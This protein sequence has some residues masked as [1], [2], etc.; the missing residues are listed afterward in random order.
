MSRSLFLL[1]LLLLAGTAAVRAADDVDETDVVV[2]T[3]NN[4]G[5]KIKSAKYALVSL[6]GRFL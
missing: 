1:G 3:D 4:F 5:D 2:L 6:G